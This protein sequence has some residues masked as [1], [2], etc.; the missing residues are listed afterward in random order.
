MEKLKRIS[1]NIDPVLLEAIDAY[2]DKLHIARS[3]AF[4]VIISQYLAGQ[5]G[6]STLSD[7]LAL[8]KEQQQKDLVPPVTESEITDC[9]RIMEEAEDFYSGL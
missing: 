3:S 9:S 4:S 6:L 5:K 8:Y 7:L 2:A 1:L